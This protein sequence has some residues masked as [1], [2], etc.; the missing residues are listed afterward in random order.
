MKIKLDSYDDNLPLNKTL[1]FSDLNIIVESVFQI[2]DKYHPQ[3]HI[4]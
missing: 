4:H 3:I 1:W 2:K